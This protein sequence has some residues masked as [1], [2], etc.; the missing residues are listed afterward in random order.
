M[1]NDSTDSVDARKWPIVVATGDLGQVSWTPHNG[2]ITEED[3]PLLLGEGWLFGDSSMKQ[4][5]VDLLDDPEVDSVLIDGWAH[6]EFTESR[7]HPYDIVVAMHRILHGRGTLNEKGYRL[8]G[9]AVP[10]LVAPENND[11]NVIY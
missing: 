6:Y 4:K 8:L 1:T 11:P 2:D 7:R 10:V 3:R 9:E 5:V